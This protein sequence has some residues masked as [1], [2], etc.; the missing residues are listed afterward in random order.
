MKKWVSI[1]FSV[2]LLM[3]SS[4]VFAVAKQDVSA[5][6]GAKTGAKAAEKAVR[7]GKFTFK[8]TAQEGNL[9][10]IEVKVRDEV[11]EFGG[12]FIKK[13]GVLTI[14]KFDIDG[15][16][17]NKLGIKG[18]REIITDFGKQHG[19]SKV[20]IEGAPRITGANPGKITKLTFDVQ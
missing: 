14:K 5:R 4:L 9:K 10:F 8:T 1:V 19:V 13:D 20:V 17:T 11:L 16:M 7:K 6:E 15:N 18:I 12:D 2:Y 3:A